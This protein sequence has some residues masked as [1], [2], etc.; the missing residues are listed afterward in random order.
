MKK[1]S[2]LVLAS[3]LLSGCSTISG[4]FADEEEQEIRQLKPIEAAFQPT[5]SWQSSVGN[6]VD[7][8]YSRL[9]PALAYDKL[10]VASRDGEIKALEPQ[11]G[12][13]LWQVQLEQ[14]RESGWFD[15]FNAQYPSAKV[16][17]GLVSAYDKVFVGTEDGYVYA[18]QQDS[19]EQVWRANV[20]GEVLSTPAVDSGYVVVLTGSGL[21]L[22]LDAESGEQKWSHETEVP[23]LSLRG[24]SAPVMVSG[25]VLSGTA[26]GKLMVNVV[27]NGLVAWEQAVAAPTGATEL[28]R[29]ADIDVTP[30][31]V[32]G[33]VYV[34]SY[35]GT[36][37]AL[38]LRSGRVVW[39]REYASYLSLAYAGNSLF[40]VD[41]NS[42]VYA[43][44]RR[45]GIEL[46]SQS[47]LR[48]RGLTAAATVGDYL[49]VG[50]Q[51]GFMHWFSQQDG[52]IVARLDLG[53][54]DEDEGIYT[55]PVV[56]GK[57]IYTQTRS[58]DVYAI[59]T[60]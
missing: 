35:D 3:S 50:D 19:G 23:P 58:G 41:T 14:D 42:V 56:D 34:V 24:L 55:S 57:V 49:V 48:E 18:L 45:N 27:D 13:R 46:W 15:W 1:L 9:H 22:A 21:L 4:W 26:T 47:G 44:D 32:G 20:K 31:V 59:E 28:E 30:L 6:G 53:G 12:K 36:L 25:G 5:I 11:T 10:F 60:P 52:Q 8:Y 16:A 33:T 29:L 43:L 54:D 51:W 38:E 17:G 39:K 2:A 7:N 37:A 40:V